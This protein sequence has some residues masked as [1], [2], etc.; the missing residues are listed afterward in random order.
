MLH[1]IRLARNSPSPNPN[2][3]IAAAARLRLEANE[4]HAMPDKPA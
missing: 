1:Q 3:D 4:A 2:P